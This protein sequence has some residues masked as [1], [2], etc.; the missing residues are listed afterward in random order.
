MSEQETETPDTPDVEDENTTTEPDQ[1]DAPEAE[2]QNEPDLHAIPK[3]DAWNPDR[4][5]AK[6]RKL[7]AEVIKAKTKIANAEEKVKSVEALEAENLRLSVGYELGLP[8]E[9]VGRLQGA[10]REE[11]IADAEA[12]VKLIRPTTG[13]RKPI[14][15]LR[16]GGEPE[17]EPEERDLDKIGS[18]MFSR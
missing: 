9:L 5:M 8:R 14:E 12:L 17:Q 11:L 13:S 4:A 7:N 16:G 1:P 10:T 3:E 6:I 2:E 15:T 18:R